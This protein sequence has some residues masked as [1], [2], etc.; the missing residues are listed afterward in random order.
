VIISIIVIIIGVLLSA[1]AL[2]AVRHLGKGQDNGSGSAGVGDITRSAASGRDHAYSS[3]PASI[4]QPAPVPVLRRVPRVSRALASLP[5]DRRGAT[6]TPAPAPVSRHCTN[7]Q[8]VTSDPRGGWSDGR[9]YVN[10]D[11]WNISGYS[12][13]QTLYACAYNNWYVVADMNNDRGDGAVKTYPNVHEDFNERAISS[14]HAISSTLAETS[15]H[16]G[17]YEDAYDIWINGVASSGSTEVMIW[18]EN[19]NQ[20]PAGSAE[21]TVTF[22]GR[23]YKAWKNGS[24]I[25]FVA[26][27]N[28]TSGTLNLLEV[29]NWIIAKGWMP[30]SST[31]GQIDYGA[32]IVS[33][34]GA[35]ATFT[36]TNFSVNTS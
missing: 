24:Y 22:G 29:F 18:T 7:P 12:V 32:E 21:G 1:G 36:F 17:I 34:N 31:L 14:F 4:S 28:F 9:Y 11:M 13:T 3:M 20:V 6:P 8:F 2:A 27:T 10:N 15:P 19:C 16:A 33:T 25:A 23:A 5:A 35:A 26:D 30:A